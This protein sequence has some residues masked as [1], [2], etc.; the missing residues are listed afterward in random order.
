MAAKLDF[1]AIAA[2]ALNRAES[3]VPDWLPNGTREGHEWRCGNTRGDKGRSLSVNLNNGLWADFSGD[4]KGAD[5]ISLY[6]AIRTNGNQGEAASAL[7]RMLG[8]VVGEVN[9]PPPP[10]P[11][12]S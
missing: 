4:E 9:S 7:A 6:A 8:M 10:K 1:K 12:P 5:L 2:A 3:L 11:K